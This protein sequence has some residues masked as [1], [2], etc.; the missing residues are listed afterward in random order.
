M[1]LNPTTAARP[2][3]NSVVLREM[4]EEAVTCSGDFPRNPR[5]SVRHHRRIC[6]LSAVS[7]LPLRSSAKRARISFHRQT[8][9]RL[10]QERRLSVMYADE[11]WPFTGGLMSYDASRTD[12]YRRPLRR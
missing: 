9:L 11:E 3:R 6:D 2:A 7:L 5:I 10:A 8:I 12:S 1:G 4:R